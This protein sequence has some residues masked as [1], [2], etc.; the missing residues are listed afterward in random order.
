M[1]C[2]D[3]YIETQQDTIILII[4]KVS[5]IN[6]EIN[7]KYSKHIFDYTIFGT[8]HTIIALNN[9]Y[10]NSKSLYEL[11]FNVNVGN[12][13]WNQCKKDLTY[14]KTKTRL[15][16]SSD[17]VD[18]KLHIKTYANKEKKNYINKKGDNSTLL[19][20]NRGYGMG[21]YN[22]NY[23]IINEKNNINYLVE[24]HLI[25]IKYLHDISK[26][27]LIK[28]YKKIKWGLAKDD[29]KP[30]D[31]FRL[32]KGN[33]AD[34]SIVAKYCVKDCRLVN[35]LVNKLEVIT[36]NIEMANVCYVP[37]SYLFVWGQGF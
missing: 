12:I 17:I 29:V 26:T 10:E 25:C 14:D 33:S 36:K 9:L 18:N 2:N 16:Y 32:Q 1:E 15:I 20:I 7:D 4:K 5:Q 11:D 28:K 37:L 24:N 35:L 3:S 6:T 30:Q 27:E 21:D 34:R 31:I 22:F 23:C 8:E 13:V 19:V